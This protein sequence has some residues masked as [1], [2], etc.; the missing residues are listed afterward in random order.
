ME[1]LHNPTNFGHVFL[2]D[3]AGVSPQV[4]A[5]GVVVMAVGCFVGAEQV[6]RI[7]SRRRAEEPPPSPP[8]TRRAAFATFGVLTGLA[9]VTLTFPPA[10]EAAVQPQTRPI[11]GSSSQTSQPTTTPSGPSFWR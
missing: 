8:R 11:S 7:F 9:L 1:S 4:V 10:P 3:L 6:E 5:I 2:Y